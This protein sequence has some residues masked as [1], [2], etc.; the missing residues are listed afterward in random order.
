MSQFQISSRLSL[1]GPVTLDGPLVGRRAV[2]LAQP[3]ALSI[4]STSLG[5]KSYSAQP[6]GD[7]VEEVEDPPVS[8]IRAAG[9]AWMFTAPLLA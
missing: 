7:E 9:L 3:S 5:R 6:K 1:C 2:T 4:W 8:L